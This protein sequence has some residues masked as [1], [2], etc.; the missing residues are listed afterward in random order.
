M[1]PMEDD[2]SCAGAGFSDDGSG[3]SHDEEAKSVTSKKRGASSAK[4]VVGTPAKKKDLK[5]KNSEKEGSRHKT[6]SGKSWN[7]YCR[8]HS[9]VRKVDEFQLNQ[10]ICHSAKQARDN[11][12]AMATRQQCL[13]FFNEVEADDS[14]FQKMIAEY[15]Q[16]QSKKIARK[17]GEVHFRYVPGGV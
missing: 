8:A 2:E 11:L 6:S 12:R 15:E 5:E 1:P 9:R 10:N 17:G 3:D 4:S 7:K 14:R 13:A 16:R